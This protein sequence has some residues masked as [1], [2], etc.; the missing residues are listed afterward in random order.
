MTRW[1][2][3]AS[4]LIPLHGAQAT[5]D[6]EAVYNRVCIACHAGQLPMAPQKGDKAAWKP[7][8]AQGMDVLVQ[9]VTQGFKAMPPRGLCMDC[10]AEDYRSIIRW[11]SE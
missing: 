9:H 6:P 5:Q 3:A 8:M 2:L 11:M 7:R 4:V 10:S 1:L